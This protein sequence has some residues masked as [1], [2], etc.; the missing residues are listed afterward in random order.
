MSCGWRGLPRTSTTAPKG[1]DVIEVTFPDG[2][3]LDEYAIVEEG[4]PGGVWEW[5]IPADVINRKATLRLLT[6]D[7]VDAVKY[8]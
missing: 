8:A 7:E 3:E 5:C 1:E 2:V 4:R 6:E